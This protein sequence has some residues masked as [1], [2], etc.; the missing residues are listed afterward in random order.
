[1]DPD[2][3]LRWT[4]G[5]LWSLTAIVVSGGAV[6]LTGSGLGCSDWPNCEEDRFVADLEYHALIEFVNR[7][8]TGVV[9]AAVILAVLGSRRRRPARPDLVRWSWGL[10][11]GVLGQ[12]V[13]GALLVRTELDPR[14]TMGHFL[15]S[16]VLLWN[17]VVLIERAKRDEPPPR[18]ERSGLVDLVRLVSAGGAVLLVSG[19]VVTGSG[20]HS[21]SDEPEVAARLPLLVREVT[22][23]HSLIAI[24]LLLLV[25]VTVRRAMAD[26]RPE[27][28]GRG[29]IVA[30]LLVVQGSVGYAQYFSGVPVLLV[31]VHITLASLAWI[32]IV[33]LHLAAATVPVGR[34]AGVA[35]PVP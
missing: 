10:V 16:M 33:R 29:A 12:I 23:I 3:Y 7:L 34:V 25:I 30:G 35:E 20:P 6:R 9:A 11:A 22:R 1:M 27:V 5:A 2:R 21:G 13:L 26:G 18:A 14:F 24:G 15:L 28:A 19:T 4:R 32:A 17:A 8:F 31:G